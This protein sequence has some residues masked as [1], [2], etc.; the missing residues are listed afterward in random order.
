MFALIKCEENAGNYALPEYFHNRKRS[1][2]IEIMES[3]WEIEESTATLARERLTRLEI[4]TKYM[5]ENACL[6]NGEWLTLAIETLTNNGIT[7]EEFSTAMITSLQNGRKKGTNILIKG[8]ANCGKSFLFF[9]LKKI[10]NSFCNPSPAT[11]NWLGIEN[12]EIIFLNDFR[13]SPNVIPWANFLHLLEGDEV[14]FHAP[15]NHYH[16]DKLT[17]D[18]QMFA[19]SSDEVVSNQIG[20]LMLK[21]TKMMKFRIIK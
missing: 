19:T 8:E 9:P 4:V 16:K 6:C 11:F 17:R 14:S 2:I 15:K 1:K 3:T 20:T 21:E 7:R 13:W 18:T 5:N 10:F 12:A